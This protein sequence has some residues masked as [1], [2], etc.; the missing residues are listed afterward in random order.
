MGQKETRGPLSGWP[1]LN[2]HLPT[3]DDANY[4]QDLLR[5]EIQGKARRGFIVRIHQRV[6]ALRAK[7][8]REQLMKQVDD[9]QS[10]RRFAKM[11]KGGG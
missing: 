10:F 11:K 7:Q 8:E 3:V 6:C 5:Q 2:E 9:L 1:E 4:A